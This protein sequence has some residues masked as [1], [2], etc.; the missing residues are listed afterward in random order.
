MGKKIVFISVA[1]LLFL[2][3]FA[4][5]EVKV[6]A[7]ADNPVKELSHN[8]VANYFLKKETSWDNGMQVLPV[9]QKETSK[10]H[11]QFAKKIIGKT[12]SAL[13]AYWN[14]NLFS[15]R[16]IPPVTKESDNEVISYVESHQGAIGYVSSS[17]ELSGVKTISIR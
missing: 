8:Q 4:Y 3:S 13:K 10:I 17:A 9:Y 16:A 11:E 7:N 14:Q 15:G 6:I 12:V 2:S 5:A 1:V